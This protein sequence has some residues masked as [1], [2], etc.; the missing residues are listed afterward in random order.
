LDQKGN[1]KAGYYFRPPTGKLNDE[2][3]LHITD[4]ASISFQVSLQGFQTTTG[5]QSSTLC[6]ILG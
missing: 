3:H 2:F 6:G 1:K 4:A 5:D